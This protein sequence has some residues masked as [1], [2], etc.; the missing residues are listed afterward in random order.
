MTRSNI[1]ELLPTSQETPIRAR[2]RTPNRLYEPTLGRSCGILGTKRPN[3]AHREAVVD[4]VF[5]AGDDELAGGSH[6][7]IFGSKEYRFASS[8]KEQPKPCFV[9]ISV[10]S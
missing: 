8:M 3:Y 4:I 5:S 10:S 1:A 2:W 7:R 6:F 9:V